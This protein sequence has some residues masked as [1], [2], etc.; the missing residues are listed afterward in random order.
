MRRHNTSI[1]GFTLRETTEEDL[2]LILG[3]IKEIAEYEK[4]SDAVMQ[5]RNH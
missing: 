4:L 5:Q 3:F 2:S 1:K